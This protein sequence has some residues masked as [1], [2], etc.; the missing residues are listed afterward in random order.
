MIDDRRKTERIRLNTEI[1]VYDTTTQI[2]VGRLVDISTEGIMVAGG[3]PMKVNNIYEFRILL[4]VSIYGKSEIVFDAHCLWC[5]KINNSSKYQAGFQLR[6]ATR[7]L[8]EMIAF[9]MKNQTGE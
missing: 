9:W 2:R 6:G 4:P 5:Q 8:K 7:E 1:V 3:N